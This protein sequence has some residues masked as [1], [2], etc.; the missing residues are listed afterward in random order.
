MAFS[1]DEL[2]AFTRWQR[3]HGELFNRHW[4]ELHGIGSDDPSA[5]MRDPEGFEARVAEVTARQAPVM[6][7]HLDRRPLTDGRAERVTEAI[8]GIFHYEHAPAGYKLV[9]AR[10]EVRLE[11]ARRRFGQQAIDDIV[12]R[13]R[14]ILGA[15]PGE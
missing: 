15:L 11:A 5:A 8:G 2:V 9:V 10:D 3:D 4:A 1:D 14:L 12:A 6:K 7:A 13:E